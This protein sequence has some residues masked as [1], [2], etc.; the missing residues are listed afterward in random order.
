MKTFGRLLVLI[1]AVVLFSIPAKA[2]V[3]VVNVKIVK[4]LPTK[5]STTFLR[6]EEAFGTIH[7]RTFSIPQHQINISWLKKLSTGPEKLRNDIKTCPQY[8][9]WNQEKICITATNQPKISELTRW[10]LQL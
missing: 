9:M 2:E 5:T 4:P 3:A 7:C 1:S 6:L 8:L 10:C